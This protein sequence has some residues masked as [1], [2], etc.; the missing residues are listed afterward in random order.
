MRRR[1]MKELSKF[2]YTETIKLYCIVLYCNNNNNKMYR[3]KRHG[4][5]KSR[6][7]D[8]LIY[9]G[10]RYKERERINDKE[11]KKES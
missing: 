1:K 4:E 5:W 8:K 3:N 7:K 11:I 6:T 2:L 10:T 9:E